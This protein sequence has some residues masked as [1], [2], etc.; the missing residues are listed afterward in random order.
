AATAEAEDALLLRSGRPTAEI[1]Q[2]DQE[3][4]RKPLQEQAKYLQPGRG[5]LALIRDIHT[6]AVELRLQTTQQL[7][8]RG[9]R[10]APIRFALEL[11]CLLEVA[12]DGVPIDGRRL[13]ITRVDLMEE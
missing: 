2:R 3:E 7:G 11:V 12:G 6:L 8:E 5:G 1:E 9:G 10:V 4:E 13:D